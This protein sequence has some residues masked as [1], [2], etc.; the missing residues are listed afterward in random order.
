MKPILILLPTLNRP[1]QLCD[2]IASFVRWGT[3][4][5]DIL[6]LGGQGGITFVLNAVPQELIMEYEIIGVMGDDIRMQTRDWDKLVYE[7]L[8]GRLGLVHGRDGIQ[9]DK[10]PT[11]PFISSRII[12]AL[13]FIQP[14][15]LHHFYGD[16]FYQELLTPLG[17][18]QYVPELFTEHL[19]FTVGKSPDDPTY[20]DG[21][22][23]WAHD[24]AAWSVYRVA[25]LPDDIRRVKLLI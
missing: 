15:G 20:Q 17:L 23:S 25:R 9:N 22:K 18:I 21:Y 12:S 4:L 5:A 3:G 11:H 19:H 7:R 2:A 14:S 10:L 24:T 16:N 13:G 1:S 8:H 6:T